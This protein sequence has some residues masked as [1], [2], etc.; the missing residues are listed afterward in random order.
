MAEKMAV[1]VAGGRP[2]C[3]NPALMVPKDYTDDTQSSPVR[4]VVTRLD[5]KRYLATTMRPEAAAS[6]P[7]DLAMTEASDLDKA[8]AQLVEQRRSIIEALAKGYQRGQTESHIELLLKIQSAIDV[9]DT[10]MAEY[11][12]D[13]TLDDE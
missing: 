5:G 12:D 7:G 8:R 11:E 9:L 13:D 3:G 6:N 2:K 10:L 4:S 1:D